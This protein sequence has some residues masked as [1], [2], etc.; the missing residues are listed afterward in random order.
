M[1][2]TITIVSLLASVAI[3]QPHKPY[4]H[5]HAKLH[6]ARA[7]EVEVK[8]VTDIVYETEVVPVTETIWVSDGFVPPASSAPSTTPVLSP[9]QFFQGAS[10]APPVVSSTSTYVAPAPA[11]TEVASKAPEKAPAPPAPSSTTTTTTP[12][13]APV[14]PAYTPEPSTYTPPAPTTTAVVAPAPVASAAPASGST[15]GES[16]G[17]SSGASSYGGKTSGCTAG[18]KCEG[19]ITHYDAS[20]GYSSCGDMNDGKATAVVAL[21]KLLLGEK[22]NGN[23]YCNNWVR[24]TVNGQSVNAKVVDKCG[25]CKMHDLDLSEFAF[26]SLGLD[27]GVGRT[28]AS[29]Q[30]IDSP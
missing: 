12:S 9:A 2:S 16:S 19:E 4:E 30:F 11:K 22:G 3:A 15:S 29:W 5:Q 8:W 28:T 10:S 7:D 13:P 6:Q 24:I 18:S 14:V 17:G 21:S 27:L 23:P 20:A 25:S 1:K 26:T